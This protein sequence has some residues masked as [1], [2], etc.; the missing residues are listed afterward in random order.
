MTLFVDREEALILIE[1]AC[2]RWM[3]DGRVRSEC[4]EFDGW[5]C[6][7]MTGGR[8][9]MGRVEAVHMAGTWENWLCGRG[10]TE[11]MFQLFLRETSVEWLQ[12]HCKKMH[13]RDERSRSVQLLIK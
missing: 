13:M 11:L 9:T 10:T 6:G 7:S 3:V 2:D 12:C 8:Q 5:R 4:G 1:R